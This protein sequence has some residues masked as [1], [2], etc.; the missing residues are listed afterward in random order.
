MIRKMFLR[1][2]PVGGEGANYPA[3]SICVSYK[4]KHYLLKISILQCR[5]ELP[6][7]QQYATSVWLWGRLSIGSKM[8]TVMHTASSTAC[9][10]SPGLLSFLLVQVFQQLCTNTRWR[11]RFS[12]S[13]LP[14]LCLQHGRQREILGRRY[15]FIHVRNAQTAS[16]RQKTYVLIKP[17]ATWS[18]LIAIREWRWRFLPSTVSF[19]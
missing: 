4:I 19:F 16:V 6:C 7:Q 5:K 2:N 15:L 13:W 18:E 9:L 11:L 1:G 17:N 8:S 3:F 12:G 14:G 10:R